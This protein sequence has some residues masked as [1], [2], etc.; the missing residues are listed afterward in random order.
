MR[1][2]RFSLRRWWEGDW[3]LC[4]LDVLGAKFAGSISIRKSTGMAYF[5]VVRSRPIF[6]FLLN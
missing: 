5:A 4:V 1:P 6:A 3:R 2:R